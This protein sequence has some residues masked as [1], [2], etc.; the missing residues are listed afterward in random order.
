MSENPAEHDT[1]EAELGRLVLCRRPIEVQH[2]AEES[3][4]GDLARRRFSEPDMSAGKLVDRLVADAITSIGIEEVEQAADALL[5][6]QYG[7]RWVALADR[8]ERAATAIAEVTGSSLTRDGF[9]RKRTSD[10]RS[11]QDDILEHVAL[12]VLGLSQPTNT[13][14]QHRDQTDIAPVTIPPETWPSSFRPSSGRP[15]GPARRSAARRA[16]TVAALVV[17]F[18][19]LIAAGVVVAGRRGPTSAA[20]AKATAEAAEAAYDCSIAPAEAVPDLEAAPAQVEYLSRTLADHLHET[21]MA[22]PDKLADFWPET[23]LIVQP[24]SSSATGWSGVLVATPRQMG[25]TLTAGQ[26]TGLL[27]AQELAASGDQPDFVPLNEDHRE[28]SSWV[29]ADA[30]WLVGERWGQPHFLV[31]G[32]WQRVWERQNRIDGRLGRPT[33]FVYQVGEV[34]RQ[35]FAGGYLLAIDGGEPAPHFDTTKAPPPVRP[36]DRIHQPDGTEW[37]IGTDRQRIWA[38]LVPDLLPAECSTAKIPAAN[39][40][41]RPA[42]HRIDGTRAARVPLSPSCTF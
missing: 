38:G 7:E 32:P 30:G 6:D 31:H 22:C 23:K 35:D 13:A 39:G 1:V 16:A 21:G 29:E 11:R 28:R 14:E 24:V 4:L 20:D 37:L 19:G 2:L 12:G 8:Q 42:I 36:G 5:T 41:Q 26:W 15:P 17:G 3:A 9:R 25:F 40:G 18:M 34:Q 27:H 10:G 33:S